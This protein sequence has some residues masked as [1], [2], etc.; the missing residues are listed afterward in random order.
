MYF[1]D[2]NSDDPR[3]KL[4]NSEMIKTREDVLELEQFCAVSNN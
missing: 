3:S 2:D 4:L 1:L